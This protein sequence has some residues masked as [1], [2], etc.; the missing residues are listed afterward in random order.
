MTTK[1]K[2]NQRTLNQAIAAVTGDKPELAN[3]PQRAID[4]DLLNKAVM[5]NISYH[6][7]T[8]RAKAET[9]PKSEVAT[10]AD[11]QKAREVLRSTMRLIESKAYDAIVTKN[12]AT[13]SQIIQ[14][15][16]PSFV[17][18]GIWFVRL[19]AVE[20]F[21]RII[22]E[23]N[24]WL[25]DEG[26][27]AL[28]ADWERAKR[29][30]AEDFERMAAKFKIDNPFSESKYPDPR[31]LRTRFGIE[32]SWVRFAVPNDLPRAIREQEEAKARANL[33]DTALKI[34]E[35]LYAGFAAIVNEALDKLAPVDGEKRIIKQAF[36]ENFKEFCET[37]RY[38]NLT[39][40]RDLEEL[41]NQAEAIMG[42]VSAETLRDKPRVRADIVRKLSAVKAEV[43]QAIVAAPRRRLNLDVLED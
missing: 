10:R 25:D 8:N 37:F 38:R 43:D 20:E 17:L 30:A 41:V 26:V 39:D 2:T 21:E 31:Y 29:Q 4:T 16:M 15:C 19:D 3:K 12:N 35:A 42:N 33:N 9:L 11:K 28:Q 6:L 34:E 18:D 32:H 22:A 7:W 40:K 14:R 5:L 27:P 13:K 1:T 24:R 23:Y 36:V